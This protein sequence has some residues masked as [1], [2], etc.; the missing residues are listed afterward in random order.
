MAVRVALSWGIHGNTRTSK[1]LRSQSEP[2]LS[3]RAW[4][5]GLE[6]W[7]A[8]V[9]QV[10]GYTRSLCTLNMLLM[11]FCSRGFFCIGI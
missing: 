5:V 4:R 3:R 1:N 2:S 11:Y 10:M 9:I 6:M 7:Y 8:C